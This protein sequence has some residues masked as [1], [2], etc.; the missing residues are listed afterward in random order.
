VTSI[1]LEIDLDGLD[2]PAP[3]V[4]V[5]WLIAEDGAEWA[6]KRIGADAFF[7]DCRHA[8]W[9]GYIRVREGVYPTKPRAW[10]GVGDHANISGLEFR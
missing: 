2:W 9:Y 8:C 1:D 7:H 5:A 3:D 6:G 10:I 4:E